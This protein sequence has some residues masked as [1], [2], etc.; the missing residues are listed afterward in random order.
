MASKRPSRRKGQD[1]GGKPPDEGGK[2]PDEG[3]KPPDEG[4]KPP[5]EGD[6]RPVGPGN[7]DADPVRIHEA[8]VERR[9]S[10]GAP[11]TAE[12]YARAIRQWHE[13][14]GAVG[15]PPT[16]LTEEDAASAPDEDEDEPPDEERPE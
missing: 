4:G 11:A 5:D 16:E 6:E 14:P 8:Y 1:K 9:L 12:A 13:L 15:V 3:G 2:P 7:P 10:G